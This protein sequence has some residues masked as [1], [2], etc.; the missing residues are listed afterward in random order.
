MIKSK[1]EIR[2]K[3]VPKGMKILYEDNAIVVIDKSEGLLSVQ[4]NYEKDNTAHTLLTNYI[5]KGSARSTVELFVVHRLDRETSGLLMFAKSL[6]IRERLAAQWTQVDKKY[7]ALVHGTLKEKSGIIESYLADDEDY[8]VRSVA[9]PA[10]GKFARTQYKVI[11]E[12]A[13]LSL[14]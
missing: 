1:I 3:Y 8:V 10:D 14:V 7:L 5:R 4:A 2:T 6:A 13:K 11:K 9:S 12:T